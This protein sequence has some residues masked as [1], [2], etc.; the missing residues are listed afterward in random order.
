M[1]S[2]RLYY[3]DPYLVEFDA[4]VREARADPFLRGLPGVQAR[5]VAQHGHGEKLHVI[6]VH[7]DQHRLGGV[8]PEPA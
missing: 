5:A 6:P 8:G 7:A 1:S 3:T 2:E 4:V